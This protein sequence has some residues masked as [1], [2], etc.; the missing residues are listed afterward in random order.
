M[1][2]SVF[3]MC[4]SASIIII[5]TGMMSAPTIPTKQQTDH[6]PMEINGNTDL[7]NQASTEGWA[8]NG[9]RTN[10]III[11]D[12]R[13]IAMS[14]HG[15]EIENVDLHLIIDNL[16]ITRANDAGIRISGSSNI[17]IRGNLLYAM[18]SAD[19]IRLESSTDCS[20]INNTM[21]MFD[22]IVIGYNGIRLVDSPENR[23]SNNTVAR[24]VN[25]GIMISGTSDRNEISHNYLDESSNVGV[26]VDSE[27]NQIHHNTAFGNGWGIKVTGDDNLVSS[28]RLKRNG[29]G[30]TLSGGHNNLVR[31]NIA[32]RNFKGINVISALYNRI[33]DNYVA[34]SDSF[35]VELYTNSGSG[36]QVFA[37]HFYY[38]NGS[39]AS[40]KQENVQASDLNPGNYWYNTTSERGNFWY[41]WRGVDGNSDGI[42][43]LSYPVAGGGSRDMK[44][45]K[46]PAIPDVFHPPWNVRASPQSTY[47]DISWLAPF[48][49][50]GIEIERYLI[51]RSER[52]GGELF[53]ASVD[54]SELLFRDYEVKPGRAYYYYVIADNSI[55]LSNQSRRVKSSPDTVAPRIRIDEPEGDDFISNRTVTVLYTGTDN[56]ALDRFEVSLDGGEPVDKGLWENITFHELSEGEHT[57][58][59]T[60]FDL[61]EHNDT[62]SVS[63][64]VDVSD[65]FI[66]IDTGEN[67]HLLTSMTSPTITWTSYDNITDIGSFSLSLDGSSY[68]GIGLYYEY[69]LSDLSPGDH[70]VS[71]L[72]KDM[73][74]N[75]K[76]DTLNV[77]VDPDPP[78]LDIIYPGDMYVNNTGS[79]SFKWYS[80]DPGSNISRFLIRWGSEDWIDV[81]LSREYTL[82]G[83]SEGSHHIYIR[84][85]DNAGN[86]VTKERTV[87]VDLNPPDLIVDHPEEGGLYNGEFNVVWTAADLMTGINEVVLILDGGSPKY[88]DP[89]DTITIDFSEDGTHEIELMV[90]DGAG[91][92]VSVSRTFH[93]DITQP[94]VISFDPTGKGV[95]VSTDMVIG[96]SEEMD[97]SSIEIDIEDV[98]GN[99]NWNGRN[100]TFSP[101]QPLDYGRRYSLRITGYDMAG[102]PLVPFDW[103]FTTEFDLSEGKGMITG[104]VVDGSGNPLPN[105]TVRAKSGERTTT[106]E[107]GWFRFPVA[108]GENHLI[109][110]LPGYDDS[111]FDFFLE[112]G[113]ILEMGDIPVKRTPEDEKE[114]ESG[115]PGFIILIIIG[116]IVAAGFLALVGWQLK[117][118]RDTS[119]FDLPDTDLQDQ[120]GKKPPGMVTREYD[121]SSHKV[122]DHFNG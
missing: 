117:R 119:G 105:A 44:P 65:P 43:D 14:D 88:F 25:N 64:T 8:G 86:N 72:A 22:Q 2:L 121:D 35:G 39:G 75:R 114:E 62:A 95:N 94:T 108:E 60:V 111:K 57:V 4:I 23:I 32:T 21:D 31:E 7:V 81:G 104:R 41:D 101:K 99:I 68:Q 91:N 80:M 90:I 36:N 92:N 13:I 93:F 78:R 115:G 48:Y 19:A 67:G 103:Y 28:N 102:N 69:T 96:F 1:A 63:F 16:N 40:F 89:E 61:A 116:I 106:N 112:D 56:I 84:S 30:I 37:N 10:P 76:N 50:P 107:T 55:A 83:L 122:I 118:T 113:Q 66:R 6:F 45:L 71:I 74:G 17:T 29:Y 70:T 82:N 26:L 11:S 110:S 98:E 54:G 12:Y 77:T 53:H 18:V 100:L 59:V 51:Y 33:V 73:A 109:V 15:V 9:S 97:P 79:V 46:N 49:G 5:N 38:N 3:A 27:N 87:I 120:R 42:V 34:K 24:M 47:I 58:E 20:V 52:S 85:F